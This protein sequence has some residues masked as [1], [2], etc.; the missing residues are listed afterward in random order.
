MIDKIAH[1]ELIQISCDKI[2]QELNCD[3]VGFAFQNSKGPNIKWHI[4]AGNHNEKYKLITVRYGKGNA[5]RVISTGRPVTIQE[6]PNDIVGNALEYPIM[7]AEKLIF[8]F[9]VPI[10]YKGVSKGV[11]LVGQRTKR[12]LSNEEKSVVFQAAK[13]IEEWIS[14]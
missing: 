12:H 1:F 2:L 11:L 3:F 13:D 7:L 5:G 9:A 4:A 10:H 6:F 14:N 8:S